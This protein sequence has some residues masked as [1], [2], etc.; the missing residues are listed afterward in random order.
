[1]ALN[2]TFTLSPW[3]PENPC[4]TTEKKILVDFRNFFVPKVILV[5]NIR[6]E[7]FSSNASSKIL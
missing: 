7:D 4:S 3:T 2:D 5:E 1:M 6:A